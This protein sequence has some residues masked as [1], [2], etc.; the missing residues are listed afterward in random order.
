MDKIRVVARNCEGKMVPLWAIDVA[1]RVVYLTSEQGITELE[2]NGTTA[3]VVGFPVEDV[4]VEG[5][6]PGMLIPFRAAHGKK[7]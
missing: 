5:K 1:E 6:P 2:S 4:F 7:A 3:L